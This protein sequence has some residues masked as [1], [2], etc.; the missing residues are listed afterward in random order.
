[1]LPMLRT[2]ALVLSACGAS[3]PTATPSA[4]A[5]AAADPELTAAVRAELDAQIGRAFERVGAVPGLAVA[6][7]TAAGSYARGFGVTDVDTR[8]PATADTAFYI[9]SSTK[10][11]TAL[12]MAILDDRGALDLD[13]TL[14]QVAPEAF[15]AAVR[16]D[17][18]KLRDLLTHTH[19]L[20]NDAIGHRVAFTGEHEPA[21]LWRLLG[22]TTPNPKAPLGTFEYSNTGYNILTVLTDRRLGIRWQDLLHRELFEPAGM[23]RTT[24]LRSRADAERWSLARPHAALTERPHRVYLEK[25]D[26]TMQSAGGVFTSARDA[27]RWLELMIRDG[28]LAGRRVVPAAAVRATR[29]PLAVVATTHGEYTREHY[30]LGWNIGRRGDQTSIHHFGGFAGARAHISYQPDRAT[31]VAVFANVGGP[32]ADLIE[33]VATYVYDRLA[34]HP[35]ATATLAAAVA[36]IV[37]RHAQSRARIAIERTARAARPWTLTRPRAAYAGRYTH[38]QFGTIAVAAEGDT[39]HVRHGILRA[40]AEPFTKP[41]SI[42]VE[43]VPGR[44]ETMIFEL[45]ATPP[46]LVY[47]DLRFTR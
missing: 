32:P 10:S 11:Y 15:P 35:A 36:A 27:A 34:N 43:L 28:E 39:L 7:Y 12:A 37:E 6:A 29:A 16:P 42:R 20:A 41:E 14:A 33:A 22:A 31:G 1:M 5:P 45:A 26:R 21:T 19:G 24:A 38:A 30:G 13:A 8:E 3:P 47:G 4:T 9:A 17:A 25:V 18:V 23:T 44:G 40:V 2:T 46:A